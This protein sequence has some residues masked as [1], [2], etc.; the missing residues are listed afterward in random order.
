MHWPVP[1]FR[2]KVSVSKNTGRESGHSVGEAYTT[3][4]L[5]LCNSLCWW[6]T[7]PPPLSTALSHCP[8][9][10]PDKWFPYSQHHP[11]VRFRF[12]QPFSLQGHQTHC[13][14]LSHLLISLPPWHCLSLPAYPWG[15]S[16]LNCKKLKVTLWWGLKFLSWGSDRKL[17]HTLTQSWPSCQI[18]S[19]Q[20]A[21]SLTASRCAPKPARGTHSL[22]GHFKLVQNSFEKHHSAKPNVGCVVW[23]MNTRSLLQCI[24]SP[25]KGIRFETSF[26]G[27]GKE[28]QFRRNSHSRTI[29]PAHL[30]KTTFYILLGFWGVGCWVFLM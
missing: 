20:C 12:P 28:E 27:W 7:I 29:D 19:S 5:G 24:R 11:M 15:H 9:P 25:G 16:F 10:A 14:T 8:P 22:L 26:L 18:A 3:P 23:L 30:M 2:R 17:T 6:D 1:N 13:K 4:Q 21:N